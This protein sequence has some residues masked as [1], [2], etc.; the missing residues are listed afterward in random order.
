MKTHSQLEKSYCYSIFFNRDLKERKKQGKEVKLEKF[1]RIVIRI[2][3][4]DE[5][6]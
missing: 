2:K 3:V 4:Q 6:Q 1:Y 5:L